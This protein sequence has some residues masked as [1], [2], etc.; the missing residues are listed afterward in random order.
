MDKLKVFELAFES[1][2][3]F[4]STV[5]LSFFSWLCISLKIALSFLVPAAVM[6]YKRKK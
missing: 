4:T 1:E 2:F 5:T 6:T 3:A